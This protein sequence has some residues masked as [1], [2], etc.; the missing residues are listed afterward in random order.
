MLLIILAHA[1]ETSLFSI[2]STLHVKRNTNTKYIVLSVFSTSGFINDANKFFYYFIFFKNDYAK[3][4][5][6]G[7]YYHT[8]LE[9]EHN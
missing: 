6:F 7:K 2:L 9:V 5:N 8:L 1:W 4:Y 3:Y